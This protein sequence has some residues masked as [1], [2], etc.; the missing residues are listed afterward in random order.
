MRTVASLAEVVVLAI[1]IGSAHG[2]ADHIGNSTRPWILVQEFKERILPFDSRTKRPDAIYRPDKK[3]APP[4]LDPPPSE[5]V[6]PPGF[7]PPSGDPTR[8]QPE[9][10]DRPG[11]KQGQTKPPGK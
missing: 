6:A 11:N 7:D 3:V 8:P 4:G 10:G 1:S 2:G 9:P 5:K